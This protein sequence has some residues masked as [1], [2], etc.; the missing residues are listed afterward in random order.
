MATPA[1]A[2]AASPTPSCA[3]CGGAGALRCAGCRGVHYC[4]RG[5]QKA[6]SERS[7]VREYWAPHLP[8]GCDVEALLGPPGEPL[9]AAGAFERC[10]AAAMNGVIP[11]WS[12][13]STARASTSGV[14]RD[15]R[16]SLGGV[17]E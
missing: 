12:D 4:S 10:Q 7:F 6:W 9:D 2:A 15:C 14:Q 3:H 17:F 8:P 13:M 11:G 16:A 1:P 5:C